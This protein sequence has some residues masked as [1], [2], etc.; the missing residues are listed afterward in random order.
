MDV[1]YSFKYSCFFL[2]KIKLLVSNLSLQLLLLNI[3]RPIR[4]SLNLGSMFPHFGGSILC[5]SSM[6]FFIQVFVYA[7]WGLFLSFFQ[8]VLSLALGVSLSAFPSDYS[9]RMLQPSSSRVSL[10][11]LSLFS[12]LP[13]K[14]QLPFSRFQAPSLQLSE[15]VGICVHSLSLCCHLENNHSLIKKW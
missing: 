1:F 14:L 15:T 12:T 8:L 13:Y 5:K 3:T 11:S 4:P 7:V 9:R 2:N 6:R 10:S